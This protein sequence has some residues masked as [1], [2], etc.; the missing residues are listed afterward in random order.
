MGGRHTTSN[1]G[2]NK[3]GGRGWAGCWLIPSPP[4]REKLTRNVQDVW[5]EKSSALTASKR[6]LID[7]NTS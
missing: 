1:C 3:K 4:P 5:E 2:G 6:S 7:E